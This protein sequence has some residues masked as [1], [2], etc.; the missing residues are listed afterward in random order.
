[1]THHLGSVSTSFVDS[2]AVSTL[3]GRYRF[4]RPLGFG[5]MGTVFEVEDLETGA[6][7]A[8]KVMQRSSPSRLLRFKH[9]FRLVADVRHPNLVRLFDLGFDQGVWFFTME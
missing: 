6:H 5:G 7:L 1:M 4:V 9:E 8:L 2:E 3:G